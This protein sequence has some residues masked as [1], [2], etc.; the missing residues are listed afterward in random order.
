MTVVHG[1]GS[2]GSAWMGEAN[3]HILK[4][5]SSMVTATQSWHSRAATGLCHTGT[6][7]GAG[8]DVRHGRAQAR[9]G[10]VGGWSMGETWGVEERRSRR[11]GKG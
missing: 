6:G 5:V 8:A 10:R 11:G 1:L 7:A 3:T 2:C 9:E 4:L